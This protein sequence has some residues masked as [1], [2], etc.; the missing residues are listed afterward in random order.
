MSKLS[1]RAS[2]NVATPAE[3]SIPDL[4]SPVLSALDRGL[5]LPT[6]VI[7]ESVAKMRRANPGESP[8]QI[9]CG[10]VHAVERAT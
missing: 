4:P 9:G 10:I 2:A 6:P 5:S 8:A 7:V 3:L 1:R